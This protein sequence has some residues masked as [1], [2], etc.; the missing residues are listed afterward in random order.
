M[1]G[2]VFRPDVEGLRGISVAAVVLFHAFPATLSGGFAGVDVF[3]VISGFLIT[4][5]LLREQAATGR[6]DLVDFWARR[7]R[8]ILPAATLV[9]VACMAVALWLPNFDSRTLAQHVVGAS[10]FYLN[11]RRAKDGAE[12]LTDSDEQNPVLHYWS[13]AVEEQFY[14][15]WPLAVALVAYVAARGGQRSFLKILGVLIAG[16]ALGSFALNLVITPQDQ[17]F[18]YFSTLTRAW[19]LLGGALMAVVLHKA[20]LSPPQW[21]ITTLKTAAALVLIASFGLLSKSGAYPGYAALAPTL[22]AMMLLAGGAVGR[23]SIVSTALAWS[24]L[25]ALGRISYSLYLWHWPVFVFGAMA[26]GTHDWQWAWIILSVLL[27][28]AA[29]AWVET[30]VRQSRWL[31]GSTL[32]TYA[33]GAALLAASTGTA[34]LMRSIGPDSVTLEDGT[35]FSRRAVKSDRA[36]VFDDGCLVRQVELEYG[37]C[38]YGD[39]AGKRTV[40]AF[41]DSHAANWFPALDA[42]AKANGWRVMARIKSGCRPRIDEHVRADGSP[43]PECPIWQSKVLKDIE[44]AKPDLILVASIAGKRP[45][46]GEKQILDRLSKVAPLVLMRN[47]PTLP[48]APIDCLYRTASAQACQWTWAQAIV[49]DGFPRTPPDQLPGNAVVVD[50]NDRICPDGLCRAIMDGRVFMFDQ[51]HMSRSFVMRFVPDFKTILDNAK[52]R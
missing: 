37:P 21:L 1:H 32:A 43:Y 41:G 15:L 8:R 45:M 6:I 23:P 34:L 25:R 4:A 26:T 13:L 2:L 22:A 44:D 19:Q 47:S 40:V 35:T 36:V 14:L 18:A 48:E 29:Y 28:A 30:P 12:Y 33:L 31:Q 50:L 20:T 17:S 42:A 51:H 27:A 16:L 24:P 5:L 7:I 11:W 49:P 9:L 46:D 10:L 38:M 52:S 39:P 3:F